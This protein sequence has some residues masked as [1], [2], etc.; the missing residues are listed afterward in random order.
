MLSSLRCC[1]VRRPRPN[2]HLSQ[3]LPGRLGANKS[4]LHA[5]AGE[6]LAA[7]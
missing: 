5:T 6:L 1:A 7:A 2:P 3:S 4:L